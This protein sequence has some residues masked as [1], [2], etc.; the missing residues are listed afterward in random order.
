ML[1]KKRFMLKSKLVRDFSQGKKTTRYL[2]LIIL[3]LNMYYKEKNV[4]IILKYRIQKYTRIPIQNWETML[5]KIESNKTLKKK[6][7][8]QKHL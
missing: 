7:C 2:I 3:K 5:L 8:K 6:K 1:N 4:I